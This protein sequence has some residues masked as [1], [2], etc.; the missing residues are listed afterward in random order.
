MDGTGTGGPTRQCRFW[1]CAL[2]PYRR[3][4]GAPAAASADSLGL[5]GGLRP[6]R[7]THVRAGA[8]HGTRYAAV[9]CPAVVS[10][11]RGLYTCSPPVSGP[12]ACCRTAADPFPLSTRVSLHEE[13]VPPARDCTSNLTSKYRSIRIK[14]QSS[15]HF[16]Q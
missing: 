15:Q 2:G 1:S 16:N 8:L 10:L 7:Q 3:A 6:R 13:G 12:T 14:I 11:T 5:A 9:E 4:G